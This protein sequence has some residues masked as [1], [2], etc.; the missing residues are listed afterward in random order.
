MVGGSLLRLN[1]FLIGFDTGPGW[2]YFPSLTEILVTS[3]MFAIEVLGY[4][5]ITRRFPVLPREEAVPAA[6]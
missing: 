4:I 3:A 1:G 2:R 6:T 5:I